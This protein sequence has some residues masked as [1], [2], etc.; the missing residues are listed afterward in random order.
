MITPELI[1]DL[2]ELF[3]G[4]RYGHVVLAS[5][6]RHFSLGFD[7][8]YF[9]ERIEEVDVTGIEAPL[10]ALQGL[11]EIMERLTIVAAVQGYALGAGLELALSC[12]QIA[13]LAESQIGL[14]EARVGL[15]PGGRGSTLLRLHAQAS[16]KRLADVA[17]TLT[18]GM[19]SSNA[20]QARALGLLRQTDVTIYHPDR[21]ITDAKQLVLQALPPIRPTW[22][23]ADGP[24]AGMIERLIQEARQ[25]GK[26]SEYDEVIGAKIKGIFAK[27]ESYEEALE[28]ERVE[29]Q[30]LCF[31]ALTG[32]RIRH[33]LETS[34]PLRN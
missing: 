13:A 28:R 26:L 21:L 4:G 6:S 25:A 8:K 29:F 9:L 32:A 30:E 16:I 19:I 5:E 22:R 34:K 27:S 24:L 17:L 33:M 10:K 1:Q 3:D 18:E 23:T 2:T 11:G 12:S 31:R 7:L 20:D 14:P 15:L